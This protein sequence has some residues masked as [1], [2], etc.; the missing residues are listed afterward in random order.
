MIEFTIQSRTPIWTGGI[1]R[2]S[3]VLRLTSLMG[4]MRYF[5]EAILR[6]LR[7]NVCIKEEN[8]LERC[9]LDDINKIKDQLCPA[10]YFFG[11]NGWQRQFS[12]SIENNIN[13]KFLMQDENVW[14]N[15]LLNP[16]KSKD[17]EAI[18][19]DAAKITFNELTT[20]NY[21]NSI[22]TEGFLHLLM[23]V[24]MKIGY[25]GAKSRT[26]FGI[27]DISGIDTNKILKFLD[28]LHEL[29][30]LNPNLPHINN[31][32]LLHPPNIN[33][34]K[35]MYFEIKTEEVKN[36]IK[37]I[38]SEISIVNLSNGTDL[39]KF[40]MGFYVKYYLKKSFIKDQEHIKN[41][42]IY[43]EFLK[44]IKK[45]LGSLIYVSHFYS[46]K[47]NYYCFRVFIE[48][49][50]EKQKS[51]KIEEFILKKLEPAKCVASFDFDTIL[52]SF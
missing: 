30:A 43:Y 45:K 21:I 16:K 24:I 23:L 49:P 51:L 40:P 31:T 44:I 14:V 27:V 10:C 46:C 4:S 25:F 52:P 26:G 38:E 5:G 39:T 6:G 11:T 47:N 34:F 42:Y 36:L 20:Y 41:K 1:E 2:T 12:I 18:Y 17:I 3:C 48:I 15:K 8:N 29:K 19:L 32:Q 22:D 33:D 50:K 35:V 37:N 28:H 9:K 7:L 13:N